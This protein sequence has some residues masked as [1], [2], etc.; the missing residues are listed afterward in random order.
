MPTKSVIAIE[1]WEKQRGSRFKR[2]I[3]FYVTGFSYK[4]G[5][6]LKI[7]SAQYD[8]DMGK[9]KQFGKLDAESY[10]NQLNGPSFGLKTK[11]MPAVEKVL[12]VHG[13]PAVRPA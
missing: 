3:W 12:D 11:I 5:P 8:L 7:K 4:D 9:A 10:S 13:N 6:G 1:G 2:Q